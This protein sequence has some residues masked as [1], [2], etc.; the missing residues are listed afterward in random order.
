MKI[1]KTRLREIIAQEMSNTAYDRDDRDD[2]GEVVM[3][4]KRNWSDE[5]ENIRKELEKTIKTIYGINDDYIHYELRE[6]DAYDEYT[7]EKIG[8]EREIKMTWIVPFFE[9]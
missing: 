7:D 3:T 4:S 2:G 8:T 5:L 6:E 1:T 9:G